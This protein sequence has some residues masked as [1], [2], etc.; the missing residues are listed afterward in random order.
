AIAMDNARL[1]QEA[2]QANRIKDEFLAIVSHELRT[3]LNAILGWVTILRNR[4]VNLVTT[5]RALE[6]IERNAQSQKKLIGDILDL[7]RIIRG[8][9]RIHPAPVHLDYTI[10]AV[11]E[12]VRPTADLKGIQIE[13]RLDSS[14]AP[15]M[16]DAE[17]LHQI[18]WNLLSNAVK[19]TPEGGRIDVRLEQV[20]DE[21]GGCPYAQIAVNDTGQGIRPEFLPYVFEYFRQ[22]DATTTRL[23]GGLGLGLAIVRQLVEMHNGIIY[24][25]S[26]GE[27]RGATFIVQLPMIHAEQQ[28]APQKYRVVLDNFPSLDGLRVVVVDDCADTLELIAFILEQCQAQV[29]TATSVEE[30]IHA[31]AQ[32]QPDILISDIGMPDEDGYSLIRQVRTLEVDRGTPILAVAL[33]AFAR[34]EDRTRTLDAGFQVHL[35]KPVEPAEL[36]AVVANLAGRSQSIDV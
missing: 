17:R 28:Q 6:T 11:I 7:S 26:Q 29:L 36:V 14:L 10:S 23:H 9:I 5:H 4:T 8:K 22:G 24:A 3:P 12:N 15:V 33:T 18:V 35:S 16:G 25:T 31:I 32:L 2:L 13:S 30:A 34:E 27:G 19:F 1:Y 21:S 20:S